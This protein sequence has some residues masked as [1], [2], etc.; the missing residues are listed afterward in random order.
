M[1]GKDGEK[2]S[3]RPTC[4]RHVFHKTYR[5]R[6]SIATSASGMQT[7]QDDV[8][9]VETGFV[10]VVGRS[11]VNGVVVSR[12]AERT[13][14]RPLQVAPEQ[15]PGALGQSPPIAV[16]LD[17]GPDNHDC[18][19]L[20]P[21]LGQ[22]RATSVGRRP[23]VILLSTRNPTDGKILHP[24]IID[25]VVAKPILPETLQPVLRRLTESRG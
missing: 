22:A 3:C 25:A 24:A 23:A 11:R 10:L 12:I 15:A 1:V 8:R 20:M 4:S 19:A 9:T 2:S 5:P 13:G 17:G 18:D 7:E 21:A 6:M 14:L 16:V